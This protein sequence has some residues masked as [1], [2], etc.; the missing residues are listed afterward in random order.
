MPAMRSL[1]KYSCW[2]CFLGEFFFISKVE[3]TRGCFGRGV[4]WSVTPWCIRCF[5][6]CLFAFLRALPW[7]KRKTIA[8]S[9]AFVISSII[10]CCALFHLFE[11]WG[12]IDFSTFL[13]R[14]IVLSIFGSFVESIPIS[15]YDNLTVFFGTTIFS[16]MMG[17]SSWKKYCFFYQYF[18]KSIW[19][20]RRV[21]KTE[22]DFLWV[23]YV[24]LGNSWED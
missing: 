17:W 11:D 24:L 22:K 6:F 20:R 12:E 10:G 13:N 19:L 5:L 9:L 21:S 15:N 8:G 1:Q 4:L 2:G 16:K 18:S 23:I 3:K 14:I 7:S